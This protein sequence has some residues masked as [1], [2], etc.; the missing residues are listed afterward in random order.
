[1]IQL[2]LSSP[3]RLA[4]TEWG[5]TLDAAAL[6]AAADAVVGLALCSIAL[7]LALYLGR[8]ADLR[9]RRI[10]WLFAALL[11]A[12]GLTLV[13]SVLAL[14]APLQGIRDAFFLATAVLAA[15][16]A[17]LLWRIIP[18]VP[19]RLSRT[20]LARRNSELAA[21]KAA[22]DLARENATSGRVELERRVAERTAE[23]VET[24]DR[25]TEALRV[26]AR[27]EEDFRVS[28]EGSTVGKVQSEPLTGRIIRVNRAFAAMLGYAPDELIGRPGRDL[29]WPDDVELQQEDHAAVVTG[30]ITNYVR[31]RRYLHRDGT[32]VW[33]RVSASIIRNRG[34]GRPDLSIGVVENIHEERKAREA[35]RVAALDLERTVEERTAALAQ[36]D[37]LLREVYHRVKNNL[38]VVDSLLVMQSH[39]LTDPAA[40]NG[41]RA[42][43]SRIF[44]L[45]LVH[46]QLMGSANLQTFDIAPFL[47]ELSRNLVQ[48]V[49]NCGIG[50]TVRADALDVGL[51]FAIP[52][53]LLVTE[54]VTNALRHAFP[55]GTGEIEVLLSGAAGGGLELVVSDNGHGYEPVARVDETGLGSRIIRGLVDQL[56]GS[57]TV[58]QDGGT[59]C[60]VRLPLPLPLKIAA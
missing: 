55:A 9:Y 3:A 54:L 22:A 23:L 18:S 26:A 40:R 4:A 58:R 47:G 29:V 2:R 15:A 44:A 51:D 1:M 8:R 39:A 21:E 31:E 38:Q 52:L 41:L 7:S 32:F 19:A 56:H 36:R 35:L 30:D 11:V 13:L 5:G 46:H 17:A 16:A 28:F 27:A 53:G 25:L 48:A 59:Q 60:H 6:Q 10:A 50:L 43:R 57:M 14:W 24:N 37:L 12:R 20:E 49:P 45:G 33:G 42:L 34:D